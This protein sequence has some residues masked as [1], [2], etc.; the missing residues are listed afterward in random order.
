MRG[1]ESVRAQWVMAALVI[2][3]KLDIAALES[4]YAD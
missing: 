3:N 4:A 2:V 1:S